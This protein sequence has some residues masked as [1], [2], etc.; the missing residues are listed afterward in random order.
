MSALNIVEV[1]LNLN[2]NH[3]SFPKRA[4]EI[5]E[6]EELTNP[7]DPLQNKQMV[8]IF[9]PYLTCFVRYEK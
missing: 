8:G 4:A 1:R 7:E 3:I 5:V 2:F 6:E 9:I